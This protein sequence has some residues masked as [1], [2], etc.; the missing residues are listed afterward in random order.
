LSE[1]ATVG[2]SCKHH[3]RLAVIPVTI[4]DFICAR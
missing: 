2:T 1:S 4:F 3:M